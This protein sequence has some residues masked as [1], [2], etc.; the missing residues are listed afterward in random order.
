MIARTNGSV[1]RD[2]FGP[3]SDIDVLVQFEAGYV[4]G[5][6]F[7]R[8]E[9]EFGKIME[10]RRVDRRSTRRGA[11]RARHMTRTKTRASP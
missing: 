4:P 2:D 5:L 8:M 9:R 7:V 6:S 11:S 3:G 1:L 10:G